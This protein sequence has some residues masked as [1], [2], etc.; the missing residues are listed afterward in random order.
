MTAV[1]RFSA[2][3]A[4][5]LAKNIVMTHRGHFALISGAAVCALFIFALGGVLSRTTA[6]IHTIVFDLYL[7]LGG[8]IITSQSFRDIHAPETAMN[9]L[10]VPASK[11]E[12]LLVLLWFTS[13]GYALFLIVF[14]T[15]A[16]PV[17][18][19]VLRFLFGRN[20]PLFKPFH[21]DHFQSIA[22]YLLVQSIFF[23]GSAYFKSHRFIKTFLALCLVTSGLLLFSL[24]A[25][26]VVFF[27]FF[28]GF[29][30]TP[31]GLEQLRLALAKTW[32]GL[33][34][35]AG[36]IRVAGY[37]GFWCVLPLSCWWIAYLRLGEVEV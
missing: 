4:F 3:R 26:R 30:P 21:L 34:T 13:L 33:R 20:N 16:S 9:W 14:F 31:Q 6:P 7:F 25:V 36:V 15:L 32:P 1:K 37:F 35:Y 27:D 28:A 24:L 10:T 2:T 19:G 12:K 22:G 17:V 23:L 11:L 8:A 29:V 5:W 18:E